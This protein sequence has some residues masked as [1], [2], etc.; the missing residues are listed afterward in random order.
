MQLE[1]SEPEVVEVEGQATEEP[2]DEEESQEGNGEQKQQKLVED[3]D[4]RTALEK[5]ADYGT[6]R[7]F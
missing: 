4:D 6:G 7:E 5:E 1:E 3:E 2:Q